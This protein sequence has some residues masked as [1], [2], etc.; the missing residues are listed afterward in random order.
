[1]PGTMN[2]FAAAGQSADQH[3]TTERDFYNGRLAAL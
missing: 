2:A 3:I 1:M